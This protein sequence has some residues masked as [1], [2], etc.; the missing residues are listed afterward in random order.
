MV[1]ERKHLKMHTK[2][3]LDVI[4]RQ[5]GTLHK[6]IL[7]GVMNAI[8]AGATRVDVNFTETPTPRLIIADT[9]KGIQTVADIERFFETFGTPHEESEGKVWAQF[10]M[11]RG[12][13]FS[14]GKNVW[15]T[16][17]FRMTVDIDRMGLEYELSQNLPQYNGCYIDI[18][19][20]TSPIGAKGQYLSIDALERNVREQVEF[21]AVPIFF[22]GK[23]LNKDP[24]HLTWTYE[25][26][27]AYY[28]FGVGSGLT[29]YN[30]GAFVTTLSAYNTGVTGVVCS[31]KQLR[32]NFARNEIQ[33]DCEIYKRIKRVINE[34]RRDKIRK[35]R[36]YLSNEERISMLL[37]LVDGGIE[38]EDIKTV[39]LLRT[40]SG[41]T[42]KLTDMI[43][44]R[45]PWTFA[46]ADDMKADKIMQ[47]N[48]GIIIDDKL[49]SCLNY[50]GEPRLFFKWLLE[51]A[52]SRRN[53]LPKLKQQWDSIINLYGDFSSMARRIRDGHKMLSNADLNNKERL[54][55]RM[56][57]DP[58]F[59]N[60]GGR[61]IYIGLSETARAWTDGRTFIALERVFLEHCSYGRGGNATLINVLTHELAHDIDTS[62]AHV[63]DEEFYR[64]FH[65]ISCG[66]NPPQAT[67]A[68]FYNRMQKSKVAMQHEKVM[69]REKRQLEKK[70]DLL[71]VAACE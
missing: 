7:E 22:N 36:T 69:A 57:N 44:E 43:K 33:S 3:L 6:A 1:A 31:K 27:D 54:M 25:D 23:R 35:K 59:Y 68:D 65:D 14:F 58:T 19:L 18:D 64:R 10:R 42:I 40:T 34:N 9:G 49:P 52:L 70:D 37:D 71:G 2:L 28:L 15:T 62:T 13:L 30:I 17:T 53:T 38:Y 32:V 60:W 4:K 61:V 55:L 11:G 8:E 66:D 56:L 63:H 24:K 51:R 21:M 48:E 47:R 39:A 12:Q 67:I 50:N 26:D 46:P 5:A 29:V 41:R 45:L 20:Y 16:G